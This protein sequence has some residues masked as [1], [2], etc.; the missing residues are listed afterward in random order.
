MATIIEKDKNVTIECSHCGTKSIYHIAE[1]GIFVTEYEKYETSATALPIEI[2][3]NHIEEIKEKFKFYQNLGYKKEVTKRDVCLSTDE[4]RRKYVAICPKC[5]R[6]ISKLEI[7]NIK[8][9]IK[10]FPPD[11]PEFNNAEFQWIELSSNEVAN[12]FSKEQLGALV[13]LPE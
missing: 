5:G 10:I 6:R 12:Y 8:T 2:Y 3:N 13:K 7:L 4:K 1:K 9:Y 11:V